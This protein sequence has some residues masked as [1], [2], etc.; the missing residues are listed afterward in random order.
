MNKICEL[1]R[2]SMLITNRHANQLISW[3][4]S[5]DWCREMSLQLRNAPEVCHV[6]RIWMEE[7]ENGGQGQLV[8][9]GYYVTTLVSEAYWP[10]SFSPEP[11]ILIH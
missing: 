9:F 10:D 5:A 7:R 8:F 11:S 3:P 2:I 4:Q 6:L 1:L